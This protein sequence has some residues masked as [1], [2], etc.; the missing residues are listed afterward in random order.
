MPP[1]TKKVP[2]LLEIYEALAEVIPEMKDLCL[3]CSRESDISDVQAILDR[4]GDAVRG[5]LFEFGKVL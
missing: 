1:L 4:L 3:G 2:R 5:N